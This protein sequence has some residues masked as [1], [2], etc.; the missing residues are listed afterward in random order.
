[1]WRQGS[2]GWSTNQDA[3][4]G[5]GR[6]TIPCLSSSTRVRDPRAAK[7]HGFSPYNTSFSTFL[8]MIK[9]QYLHKYLISFIFLQAIEIQGI[10]TI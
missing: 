3:A 8:A 5:V 4:L 10:I 1:L 7:R 6:A 9:L 2:Q